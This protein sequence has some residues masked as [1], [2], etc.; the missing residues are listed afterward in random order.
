MANAPWI[1]RLIVLSRYI[2]KIQGAIPIKLIRYQ[3]KTIP[4]PWQRELSEYIHKQRHLG[5]TYAHVKERTTFFYKNH[6]KLSKVKI[7]QVRW[8]I[9]GSLTSI[10]I[11]IT[12]HFRSD[13]PPVRWK[14]LYLGK[15][16]FET[17]HV[18]IS[19]IN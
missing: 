6:T 14:R 3:H 17:F 11:Y 18:L 13:M 10:S 2:F 15:F 19:S 12:F 4:K 1:H 16:H 9:R 5:W 8:R 7:K